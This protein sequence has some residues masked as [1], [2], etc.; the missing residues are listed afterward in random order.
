MKYKLPLILK[1]LN[2]Y[3]PC[4]IALY[5][6][7]VLKGSVKKS[8]NRGQYDILLITVESHSF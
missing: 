7:L 5:M 6:Q 4:L 2:V 1:S 8:A 3:L